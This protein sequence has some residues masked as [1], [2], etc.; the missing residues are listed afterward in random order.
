MLRCEH[1][2]HGFAGKHVGPRINARQCDWIDSVNFLAINID[3]I[4]LVFLR[5]CQKAQAANSIHGE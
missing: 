3:S 5:A 1:K 2:G 4:P